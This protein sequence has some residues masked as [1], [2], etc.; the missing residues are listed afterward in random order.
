[1]YK[2]NYYVHVEVTYGILK[3]LKKHKK[4]AILVD[5]VVCLRRSSQMLYWKNLQILAN[6]GNVYNLIIELFQLDGRTSGSRTNFTLTAH[7][8]IKYLCM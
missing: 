7:T 3:L 6:R 5:V 4:Q 2:I 8:L 1:M